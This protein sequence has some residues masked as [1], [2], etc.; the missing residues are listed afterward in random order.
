MRLALVSTAVLACILV[1][2]GLIAASILYGVRRENRMRELR[3]FKL[4][5]M[6]WQ[7]NSGWFTNN[8]PRLKRAAELRK[9]A[10]VLEQGVAMLAGFDAHPVR[11]YM[12]AVGTSA[13][14]NKQGEVLVGGVD[15]GPA[16]LLDTNGIKTE[17]PVRENPLAGPV[18]QPV[19]HRKSARACGHD[20]R[21]QSRC[22]SGES[23]QSVE[24]RD[25]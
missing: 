19:Q 14:F 3:E 9:D 2:G 20:R 18:Q 8:W 13:T 17:L 10:E 22:G 11:I 7:H 24:H 16:L 25:W 4:A 6:G 21:Q 5:R 12:D 1:V 15:N 23:C